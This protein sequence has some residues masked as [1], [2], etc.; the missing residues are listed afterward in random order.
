MTEKLPRFVQTALV[1][2]ARYVHDR[3]T[4]GTLQI[5]RALAY[6][7]PQLDEDTQEQ[8]LRESNEATENLAEWAQFR[9]DAKVD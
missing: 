6:L 1:F 9:G 5:C 8:I 4:G 7:W 3:N 2:A